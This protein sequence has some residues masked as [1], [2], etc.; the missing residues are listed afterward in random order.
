MVQAVIKMVDNPVIDKALSW[1]WCSLFCNEVSNQSSD[2]HLPESGDREIE[3][4][5]GVLY[6]LTM[7]KM[8]AE[9]TGE[10]RMRKCVSGRLD[11][12]GDE[13]WV[14]GKCKTVLPSQQRPQM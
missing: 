3:C 4:E 12:Q 10:A 11:A 1:S 2:S 13:A 6:T 9:K 7:L 5:L 14:A 8:N